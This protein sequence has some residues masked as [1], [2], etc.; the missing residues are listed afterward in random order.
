MSPFNS[1]FDARMS[2]MI[3]ILMCLNLITTSDGSKTKCKLEEFHHHNQKKFN[4]ICNDTNTTFT[5]F[6]FIFRSPR[7]YEPNLFILHCTGSDNDFMDLDEYEMNSVG[8]KLGHLHWKN[9][10][11]TEFIIEDIHDTKCI[12]KNGSWSKINSLINSRHSNS[13]VWYP[14]HTTLLECL[15]TIH[16]NSVVWY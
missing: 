16:S 8:N 11:E 3:I 6:K 14:Y 15:V 2:T 1:S 5:L 9:G 4:Y 10:L 12:G 7:S 13:M